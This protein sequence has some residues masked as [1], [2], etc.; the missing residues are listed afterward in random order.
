[1]ILKQVLRSISG[2]VILFSDLIPAAD[3]SAEDIAAA[4]DHLRYRGHDVIV[5]HVLDHA[6]LTLPHEGP[7]RFI[8]SETGAELRTIPGAVRRAYIDEIRA[9][10]KIYDDA[11]R[12]AKVDY[13]PVDT[14]Q[15]FGHVLLSYLANR[16]RYF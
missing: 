13:V 14:A 10:Q 9:F 6:E 12:L 5:F 15:S 3:E 7:T 4:I 1:M 8:D 2:L 16:K 11:C